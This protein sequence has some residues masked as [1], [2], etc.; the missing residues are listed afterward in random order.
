MTTVAIH[1][2]VPPEVY[3]LLAREAKKAKKSPEDFSIEVLKTFLARQQ[4]F[5]KGQHLLRTMPQRAKKRSNSLRSDTARRHD[6]YLY[7]EEA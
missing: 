2:T 3:D 7:G 4:R 5:A 6:D 1:L